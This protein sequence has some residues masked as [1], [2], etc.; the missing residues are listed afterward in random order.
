[1]TTE[2]GFVLRPLEPSRQ[3]DF[4]AFFEGE[5]F[6]DNPRWRS[7][8]CQY[9]HTDHTKVVWRERTEVQNRA[10]ADERIAGGRM[11]GWLAY[12]EGRVVGW[13]NAAP[14]PLFEALADQPDPE[15]DRM[16]AIACFVVAK[17]ERRQGVARALL[18]A[19]CDGFRARGL[20]LAEGMAAEHATS[21]AENHHGPLALYLAAGFAVTRRFEDGRVLVRRAL[22]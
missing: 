2:P 6:A 15:A 18:A 17:T 19:A 14:R 13:C 7:C 20:V 5:A 10:A 1:M 22:S 11:Q 9:M 12:R 16:G 8:W 21:D 3:A 4:T